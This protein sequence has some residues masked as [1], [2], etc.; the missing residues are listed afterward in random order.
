M[1]SREQLDDALKTVSDRKKLL[2]NI[3]NTILIGYGASSIVRK[4]SVTGMSLNSLKETAVE[5]IE[6]GIKKP[7]TP[8]LPKKDTA[9]PEDYGMRI[10]WHSPCSMIA[11]LY[12]F[13][14]NVLPD[15]RIRHKL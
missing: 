5:L 12:E 1:K 4:I 7:E 9:K 6:K 11:V 13:G 14:F 2:T 3:I 15:L 10:L 8:P